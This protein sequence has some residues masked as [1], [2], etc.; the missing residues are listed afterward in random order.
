MKGYLSVREAAFE[1]ACRKRVSQAC[2]E[3]N[4]TNTGM[5]AS[6]FSTYIELDLQRIFHKMRLFP[7]FLTS[8]NI[9]I[10]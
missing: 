4:Y 9:I 7:F 3:G 10:L 6:V 5:M 1:G 8:E 2:T